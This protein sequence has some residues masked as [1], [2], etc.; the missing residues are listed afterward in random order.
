M[1][2]YY[3]GVGKVFQNLVLSTSDSTI[4]ETIQ[5]RYKMFI[6]PRMGGGQIQ[7]NM[8]KY[9]NFDKCLDI[10]FKNYLK[11]NIIGI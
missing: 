7:T 8:R 9:A 1:V 11:I 3:S 4:F 5:G 2:S 6:V 10:L